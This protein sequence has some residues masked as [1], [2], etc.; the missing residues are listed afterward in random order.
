[1]TLPVRYFIIN[2]KTQIMH[3][4]GC[5]QHTKPRSVPIRLFDKQEELENY[6]GRK[7]R[8]CKA[9]RETYQQME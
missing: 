7:L 5:C 6:A 4:F 2:D 3:I 9:C 1:M 8:L